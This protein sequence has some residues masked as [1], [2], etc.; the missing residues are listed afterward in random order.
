VIFFRGFSVFS[1][2]S[3]RDDSIYCAARVI[4]K[5]KMRSLCFTL[6]TLVLLSCG[7]DDPAEDPVGVENS[8]EIV[9]ID[10]PP[11]SVLTETSVIAANL[12]Y[13]INPQ[14]KSP[15]YGF[16]ILIQ[17]TKKGDSTSVSTQPN[18]IDL[19]SYSGTVTL[20]HSL[21][22]EWNNPEMRHPVRIHYSLSR[23]TSLTTG[24]TLAKTPGV[25]YSE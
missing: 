4:R 12:K 23:R 17:F 25:D 20:D 19:D 18:S 5:M 15:D 10:P 21:L 3:V 6:L 16:K 22:K 7:G 8:I 14:E 1:V 9:S 13:T 2:C 24:K 11:G